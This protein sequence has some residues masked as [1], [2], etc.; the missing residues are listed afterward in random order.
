MDNDD[1]VDGYFGSALEF[2]GIDDHINIG[3][4]KILKPKKFTVSAW[5]YP[6]KAAGQQ[7]FL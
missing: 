1:W 2:D 6:E 5:I 3:D 7:G 4:R